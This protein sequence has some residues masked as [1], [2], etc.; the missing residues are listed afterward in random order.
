MPWTEWYYS[1]HTKALEPQLGFFIVEGLSLVFIEDFWSCDKH[2]DQINW[3]QVG[4]SYSHSEYIY[5]E[6]QYSSV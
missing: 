1:F 5:K 4:I 2:G 6:K 3:N